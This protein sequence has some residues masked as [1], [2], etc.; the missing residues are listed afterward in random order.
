MKVYRK[1]VDAVALIQKSGEAFSNFSRSSQNLVRM[2]SV[3]DQKPYKTCEDSAT[4]FSHPL[5]LLVMEPGDRN[6]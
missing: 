1:G 5:A 2:I 3:L 4:L 6:A